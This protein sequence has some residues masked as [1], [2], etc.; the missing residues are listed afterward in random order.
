MRTHS[1]LS[2]AF[3]QIV[4]ELRKEAGLSQEQ[5]GYLSK[6]SRNYIGQVERAENSPT[7]DAVA[8][9]AR[10]FRK[11]VRELISAAEDRAL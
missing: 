11:P 1:S 2:V 5:L 10:A 7:L 8:A 6:L 4:R 9:L 3:G